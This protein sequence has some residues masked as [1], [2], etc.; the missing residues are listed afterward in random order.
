VSNESKGISFKNVKFTLTTS[1]VVKDGVLLDY[2]SQ[3]R[4]T[5][6]EVALHLIGLHGKKC[7]EDLKNVLRLFI[8]SLVFPRIVHAILSASH[9]LVVMQLA[10]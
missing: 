8:S 10:H 3:N 9:V 4:T 5:E 6:K 2:K 7:L 1:I